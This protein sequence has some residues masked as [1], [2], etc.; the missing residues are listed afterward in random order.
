MPEFEAF[1]CGAWTVWDSFQNFKKTRPEEAA[2]QGFARSSRP[3]RS[4]TSRRPSPS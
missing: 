3:S 4:R 1:G 2:T